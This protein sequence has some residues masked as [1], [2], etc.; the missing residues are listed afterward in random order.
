MSHYGQFCPIAKAMEVLDQRWTM[1]IMREIVYGSSRFNDI[2]R[3][4]PKMSPAL[5]STRLRQLQRVG[6]VERHAKDGGIAY[7]PTQAG[8]ELRDVL[9]AVGQWGVRWIGELGDQDLDPHLLMWDMRRRVDDG[10]L[11]PGRTVLAMDFT[12]VEPAAA[13]WWMILDASSADGAVDVCDFDPGFGID[14]RLKCSLRTLV[15][16]WLGTRSWVHA[17]REG[18][19]T[20]VGPKVLSRAVPGWFKLSLWTDVPRAPEALPSQFALEPR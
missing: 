1:L 20:V 9:E 11:P 6:L 19:L 7:R 18:D 3:G 17:Q 12:D 8:R 10:K 4:V 13:H 16:I 2:R 15:D 14:V 5:L